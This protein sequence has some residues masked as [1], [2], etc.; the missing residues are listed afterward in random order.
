VEPIRGI[1]KI[2]HK[3][4]E[5]VAEVQEQVRNMITEVET[6]RVLNL[7]TSKVQYRLMRASRE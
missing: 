6:E 4:R 2:G 5:I 1:D 3:A 7:K